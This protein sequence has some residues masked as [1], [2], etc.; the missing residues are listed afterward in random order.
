MTLNGQCRKLP[1]ESSRSRDVARQVIEEC[2]QPSYALILIA[3]V[4]TTGYGDA[5]CEQ[6]YR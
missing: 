6:A 1:S 2:S 5:K 4:A 3:G